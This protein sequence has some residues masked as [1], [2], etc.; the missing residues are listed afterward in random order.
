MIN[1]PFFL[2][3]FWV[4]FLRRGEGATTTK[5]TLDTIPK[6]H[7]CWG[8][9]IVVSVA[10]WR[11]AAQ[12]HQCQALREEF[13]RW[14]NSKVYQDT[15]KDGVIFH[16]RLILRWK[17]ST[18]ITVYHGIHDHFSPPF[19]MICLELFPSIWWCKSKNLD[20]FR[21]WN[22]NEI[23]PPWNQ[24]F[25]PEISRVWFRW[26][27]FPFGGNFG[28]IFRGRKIGEKLREWNSKIS[29]S[30]CLPRKFRED[31][32]QSPGCVCFLKEALLCKP[33]ESMKY[34]K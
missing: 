27:D 8:F 25:P 26:S 29:I 3:W 5:H 22:L 7:N 11:G 21:S 19:G 20:A 13:D 9:G 17:K 28:P 32:S 12:F 34:P 23:Y 2:G 4:F 24:H 10:P 1:K 30:F 14:F 31:A 6:K 15:Q 16:D 18:L 33:N